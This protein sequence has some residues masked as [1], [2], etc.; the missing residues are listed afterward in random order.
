MRV[1][2]SAPRL[3]GS[4]DNP[5]EPLAWMFFQIRMCLEDAPSG[6][7]PRW[8]RIARARQFQKEEPYG[9]LMAG[10]VR[11]FVDFVA[12][13]HELTLMLEE[14]LLHIDPAKAVVE[15][16]LE[17]AKAVTD[18]QLAA[19]LVTLTGE[20]KIAGSF[21]DAQAALRYPDRYLG[22]IPEPIDVLRIGRELY[23]LLKIGLREDQVTVDLASTGRARLLA[24]AFGHPV[25][26]WHGPKGESSKSV[27]VAR[28]GLRNLPLGLPGAPKVRGSWPV[29]DP[30]GAE[31]FAFDLDKGEDLG[32][33][34]SLLDGLGYREPAIQPGVGMLGGPLST[35]LTVFQLL[36]DLPDEGR[37]DLHTL[38]RLLNLDFA[39]R[40]I[41]RARPWDPARWMAIPPP[42]PPKREQVI[43][44]VI[45]D[46]PVYEHRQEDPP[47]S[48][49]LKLVNPDAD[50]FAEEGIALAPESGLRKG[51]GQKAPR[52]WYRCGAEVAQGAEAASF[53]DTIKQGWIRHRKG[54]RILPE[55]ISGD[56]V[57]C[58]FVALESRPVLDKGKGFEGGAWSEGASASGRFFFS[59]RE[60]EPWMS[61]RVGHPAQD[62]LSRVAP[63]KPIISGMYQWASV[64]D[65]AKTAREAG[66][67]LLFQAVVARRSLYKEGQAGRLPDQGRILLGLARSGALTGSNPLATRLTPERIAGYYAW[68]GWW[69]NRLQR[70]LQSPT[71]ARVQGADWIPIAT[72]QLL[73]P[74]D[75]THIV[76]GLY[77]KHNANYDT[78]AYF[79]DVRVLWWR[80]TPPADPVSG[81]QDG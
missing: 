45:K 21:A 67:R 48:G 2:D 28:L 19:A 8:V 44:V 22:F 68:S 70:D 20:Q 56:L 76:V 81:G 51:E 49:S 72:P 54:D 31:M 69:P 14:L 53:P 80:V 26:V 57:D 27:P 17:M 15:L 42:P 18:P 77:G 75:V 55:G 66:D 37:L 41:C 9:P 74:D 40:N 65:L 78:D 12:G 38:H 16:L 5:L 4:V 1:P 64:E 35:R 71:S 36:N 59:A 62:A 13:M 32:E 24:W 58:A 10:A 30:K 73:A 47:R 11:L 33:V 60:V 34:V 6:R 52:R 29:G 43:K 3:Q 25:R 50:H 79:D 7:S 39:V 61:G 23:E 63:T 46:K